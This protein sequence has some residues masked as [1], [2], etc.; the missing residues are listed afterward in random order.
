M[1]RG[2]EQKRSA[3][4]LKHASAS[5]VRLLP[6]LPKTRAATHRA[7]LQEGRAEGVVEETANP[8]RVMNSLQREEQ[9][10]HASS[11]ILATLPSRAQYICKRRNPVTVVH[12][13]PT[14][15]RSQFVNLKD[16]LEVADGALGIGE[17][18][19]AF[20]PAH[21]HE[22]GLLLRNASGHRTDVSGYLPG[23]WAG[24]S[25]PYLLCA[26]SLF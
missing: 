9:L 26:D 23:N 17:V 25:W 14:R 2:N 24:W 20:M 5:L 7:S 12:Q 15:K 19:E 13:H 11:S 10:L 22:V 1:H 8:D 4:T 16:L 3:S 18:M 21:P 6:L